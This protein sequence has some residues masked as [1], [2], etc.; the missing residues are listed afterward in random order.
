MDKDWIL[1]IVDMALKNLPQ[2]C[3]DKPIDT[4]M[5]GVFDLENGLLSIQTEVNNG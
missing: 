3:L 4:N 5:T 2:E 1:R